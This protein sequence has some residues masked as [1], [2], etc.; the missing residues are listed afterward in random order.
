[1][2]LSRGCGWAKSQVAKALGLGQNRQFLFGIE[3]EYE[4]V[5]LDAADR[6]HCFIDRRL[7]PGYIGWV[8]AGVGIVQIGLA[9]RVRDS[10]A[11]AKDAMAAFLDKIAPVFDFR[12]RTPSHIRAGFI[13]CG[14]L[15]RPLAADRRFSSAMRPEWCHP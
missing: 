6:L 1:M 8:I 13:P 9:R 4:G 15:V 10:G 14:G 11:S 5:T 2:C 7:A 12:D 3:H